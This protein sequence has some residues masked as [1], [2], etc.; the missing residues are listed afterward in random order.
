[1][2][3]FVFI[4]G[5]DLTS[6]SGSDGSSMPYLLRWK[7][8]HNNEQQF[9]PAFGSKLCIHSHRSRYDWVSRKDIVVVTINYRLGA[10]GF[11]TLGA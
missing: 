3:V 11:L 1:M 2:P 7:C 5:G 9:A 10:L 4:H 8:I 6:G